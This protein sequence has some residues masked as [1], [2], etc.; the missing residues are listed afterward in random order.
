MWKAHCTNSKKDSRTNR[1]IIIMRTQLEQLFVCAQQVSESPTKKKPCTI[2]R[3]VKKHVLDDLFWERC[4]NF[5]EVV[6]PVMNA[7]RDFY[8]GEP[9]MGKIR[10]IFCNVEK[11]IHRVREEFFEVHKEETIDVEK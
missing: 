5:E 9:C 6:A 4:T 11:H 2:S 1:V 10:H 3:D 7:L 8:S